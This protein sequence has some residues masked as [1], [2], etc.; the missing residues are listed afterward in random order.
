M[1]EMDNWSS[2]N[3]GDSFNS[4]EMR[5]LLIEA[6]FVQAKEDGVAILE[7]GEDVWDLT[8]FLIMI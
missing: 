1:A 5:K 7:I 8:N 3:I 6:T 2:I 4:K